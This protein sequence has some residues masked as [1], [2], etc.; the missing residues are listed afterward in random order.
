MLKNHYPNQPCGQHKHNQMIKTY[1][2]PITWIDKQIHCPSKTFNLHYFDNY[3]F[4]PSTNWAIHE[5]NNYVGTFPLIAMTLRWARR[6]IGEE[7]TAR[8]KK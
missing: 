5:N 3:G 2:F 8:Q 1:E 4:W 7:K 6:H